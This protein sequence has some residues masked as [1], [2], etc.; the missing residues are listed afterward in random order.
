MLSFHTQYRP[1]T[2]RPYLSNQ[3]YT[4]Y[5]PGQALKPYIVCYWEVAEP[6]NGGNVL[7]IPDTCVDLIITVNHTRQKITGRL[8]G[9]QDFSYVT[10]EIRERGE[11]ISSFAVRFHF[12]AVHLF[13]NLDF[14]ELYNQV[15][16]VELVRKEW[17]D[18]FE[19][20]FYVHGTEERIRIIENFLMSRLDSG[21]IDPNLFNSF[22]QILGSCGTQSVK[23]I[24]RYSCVS[25][26]QLE[27]LFLQQVGISIKR[28]SSLV[29]YQNVW[30]DVIRSEQ[31]GIQDAVY[32]YGYADQA[33]LLKE[34][35]RFHGV[36]PEQAK[37]IA[38]SSR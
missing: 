10:E 16:D 35:K 36:T 23:E 24:C 37:K 38:L 27:R 21:R 30:R 13:L 29:R 18:V 31:F 33:H 12:W 26:R 19:P 5:P 32:R 34:F 8:C 7:V 15:L 1:L 6:E 4:E 28:T 25:Q 3:T 20:F 14:R 2:S 9:I 22:H 17:L 11:R